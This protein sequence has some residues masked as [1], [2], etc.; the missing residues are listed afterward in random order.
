MS[1]YASSRMG[2]YDMMML[3]KCLNTLVK[4]S[5]FASEMPPALQIAFSSSPSILGYPGLRCMPCVAVRRSVAFR[6]ALE[7][8]S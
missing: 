4:L 5:A 1:T 8:H 7:Q 6:I 2:V 3:S